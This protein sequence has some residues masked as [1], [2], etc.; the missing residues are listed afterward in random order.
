MIDEILKQ[1]D[2]LKRE[3]KLLEID[4][5]RIGGAIAAYQKMLTLM[6][7]PSETVPPPEPIPATV[8]PPEA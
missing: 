1:I 5:H 7:P 2:D 8:L 3:Q 6:K 4:Y